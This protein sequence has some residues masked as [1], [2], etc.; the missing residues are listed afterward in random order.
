EST[1]GERLEDV[2][3]VALPGRRGRDA[4]SGVLLLKVRE[5]RLV[6]VVFEGDVDINLALNLL[7]LLLDLLSLLRRPVLQVS[8]G[9][10][11]LRD[12]QNSVRQLLG[13]FSV[14]PHLL[15][16]LNKSLALIPERVR[17]L[18]NVAGRLKVSVS[19]IPRGLGHLLNLFAVRTP[20]VGLLVNPAGG[21]SDILLELVRCLIVGGVGL[22]LRQEPPRKLI[23][24]G[25]QVTSGLLGFFSLRLDASEAL[26]ILAH[27]VNLLLDRRGHVAPHP[28]VILLVG[29]LD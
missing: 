14:R 6:L 4:R 17:E 10:D 9:R 15:R 7:E 18:P 2:S 13:L 3:I 19:L 25:D 11:V 20:S 23:V 26:G 1:V 21:S 12:L 5:L 27:G 16:G 29:Q 8:L 28:F 24:G 22:F